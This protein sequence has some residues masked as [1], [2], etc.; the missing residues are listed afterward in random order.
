MGARR[1][2]VVLELDYGAMGRHNPDH[3]ST[4]TNPDPAQPSALSSIFRRAQDLFGGDSCEWTPYY[5]DEMTL[6]N[7]QSAYT[8]HYDMF[9]R[10]S[11]EDWVATLRKCKSG[12]R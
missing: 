5:A 3:Q 10:Y 4:R 12:D 1:D 11:M 2:Q 9:G 8:A 7:V 6:W